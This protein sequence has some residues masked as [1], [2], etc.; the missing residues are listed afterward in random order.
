MDSGVVR[1][2]FGAVEQ[3]R[4]DADESRQQPGGGDHHSHPQR[5]PLHRVLE[6][7]RYHEV[8]AARFAETIETQAV[9]S[10]CSPTPAAAARFASDV[11]FFIAT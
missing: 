3:Q 7:P 6:R 4:R 2:D 1:V 10:T 9:A 11:T 5:S 8:P